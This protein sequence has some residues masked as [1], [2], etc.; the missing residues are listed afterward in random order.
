MTEHGI[1]IDNSKP[2]TK[3]FIVKNI[4]NLNLNMISHNIGVALL[5]NP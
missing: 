2:C 1:L 5:I 4:E 3:R